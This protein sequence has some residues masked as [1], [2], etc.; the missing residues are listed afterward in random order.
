[1]ESGIS[2]FK[3]AVGAFADSIASLIAICTGILWLSSLLKK[4]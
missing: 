3:D 1:M 4:I 2:N